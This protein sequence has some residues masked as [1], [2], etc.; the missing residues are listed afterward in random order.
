[1]RLGLILSPFVWGAVAINVFMLGLISAS[2]GWPSLSP[3]TTLIVA[4]PLTLP[5][6]WLAARWVGGLMDEAE[7]SV[8]QTQLAR[9]EAT[10]LPF[11]LDPALPV[12]ALQD[13][14]RNHPLGSDAQHKIPAV[15]PE[16]GGS[17]RPAEDRGQP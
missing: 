17:A 7:G 4:A 13:L 2:V 5:A 10:T 1:L 9:A 12:S 3:T 11:K 15:A 6:T 8:R 16:R 14:A